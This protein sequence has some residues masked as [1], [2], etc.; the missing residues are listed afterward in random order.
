MWPGHWWARW[1]GIQVHKD[2][3]CCFVSLLQ[4]SQ[5][6]N[7]KKKKKKKKKKFS[8]TEEAWVRGVKSPIATPWLSGRCPP[9]PSAGTSG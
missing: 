4:L 7:G 1:L 3:G 8:N 9:H 5:R 2:I 6:I